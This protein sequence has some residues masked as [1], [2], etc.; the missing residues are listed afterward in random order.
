MFDKNKDIKSNCEFRLDMVEESDSDKLAKKL[1]WYSFKY[2]TMISIGAVFV[3]SAFATFVAE[4]TIYPNL[5]SEDPK[6][7]FSYYVLT[8]HYLAFAAIGVVFFVVGIRG[9][10][11]KIKNG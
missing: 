10:R 4:M 3:A 2:G 7:M 11:N 6:I 1:A 8:S 9:A 5:I